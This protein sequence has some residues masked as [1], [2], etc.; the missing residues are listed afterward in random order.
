MRKRRRKALHDDFRGKS[1]TMSTMMSDLGTSPPPSAIVSSWL[2]LI[3][4]AVLFHCGRSNSINT[5]ADISSSSSSSASSSSSSSAVA[6][7]SDLFGFL[8]SPPK[9]ECKVKNMKQQQKMAQAKLGAHRC[10]LRDTVVPIPEPEDLIV[11]YIEPSH[12]VVQRCTGLCL[13]RPGCECKPKRT[14][15]TKV[16]VII[17]TNA[18]STFQM[19]SHAEVEEH[20]GPCRCQCNVLNCHYNK[21]FDEGA[22]ACRCRAEFADLKRACATDYE[23]VWR[24]ESCTCECKGRI[25]VSGHYQDRATCQCRPVEAECPAG[26]SGG[27]AIGGAAGSRQIPS[28]A[29][30]PHEDML[31][32]TAPKYIALTC[33]F[34]VALA[35]VLSVYYLMQKRRHPDHDPL[36]PGEVAIRHGHGSSA[37]TMVGTLQRAP[38]T[39]GGG[40][41]GRPTTAY[42]ITINSQSAASLDEAMLPLNEEKARHHPHPPHPGSIIVGG[43][44]MGMGGGGGIGGGGGAGPEKFATLRR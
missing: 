10:L 31:V 30:A 38:S 26:G 40:P 41:N 32:T 29:G 11:N 39:G 2:W 9:E 3:L 20:K 15:K 42:T 25:C 14:R 24:E 22:C 33:V 18:S 23:R 34:V 36:P 17:G 6:V 16:S 35:M 27:S 13:E 7:A 19:C 5:L 28:G 21:L 8:G 37:E 12:V 44:G 1:V 43:M 4:L